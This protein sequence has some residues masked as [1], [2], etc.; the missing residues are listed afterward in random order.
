LLSRIS[1]PIQ[2]IA[3]DGEGLEPSSEI[4]MTLSFIESGCLPTLVNGKTAFILKG[5]QDE[6]ESL[7]G[8]EYLLF[9]IRCIKRPEFPSV[10]IH[11]ELMDRADK[12]H[13]FDCFFSIESEEEMD[14]LRRLRDQNHFDMLFFDSKIRY[15]KRVEI[16]GEEKRR[17]KTVFD[18]ATG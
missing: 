12:P 6:I 14:L 11:F 17:I 5:P 3:W 8:A 15:L 4:E 2:T 13:R 9:W 1:K 7:R 10:G 18:E 16:T